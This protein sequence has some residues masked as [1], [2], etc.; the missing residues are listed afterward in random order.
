MERQHQYPF[1]EGIH[2][3]NSL[4]GGRS[5]GGSRGILP[6]VV[7]GSIRTKSKGLR[8][9]QTDA[10]PLDSQALKAHRKQQQGGLCKEWFA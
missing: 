6:D 7:G 2:G 5:S 3:A 4:S 10:A 1:F 8:D 9:R